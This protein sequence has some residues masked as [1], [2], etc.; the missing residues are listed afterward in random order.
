MNKYFS[1]LKNLALGHCKTS[2]ISVVKS[3]R[4]LNK[5]NYFSFTNK[6]SQKES[7]ELIESGVF[8]VLKSAAKCKHDK[9]SRTATLEELGN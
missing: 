5:V 4:S 6:V 2:Q 8:E 9:L 3:L 7:L 1:L